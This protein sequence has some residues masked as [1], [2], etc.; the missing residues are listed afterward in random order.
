MIPATD[1]GSPGRA[2]LGLLREVT[3]AEWLAQP[4]FDFALLKS[5]GMK[6][7]DFRFET[8]RLQ[9][10]EYDKRAMYLGAA[11]SAKLGIGAPEFH[12]H[13]TIWDQAGLWHVHVE[14]YPT[15]LE[16]LPS[17]VEEDDA[18]DSWQYTPV[19]ELMRATGYTFHCTE[20]YIWQRQAQVF[21]P[22]YERVRAMRQASAHS[23][24]ELARVK[25]IYTVTFGILAHELKDARPGY[26]FR[27]DWFFG[28]VSYAKLIMWRQMQRV[29]LAEGVAPSKVLVDAVTYPRLVMGLPVGDGIGQF[30]LK[31]LRGE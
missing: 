16:M 3:P 26:L 31:M 19:V 18:A 10:A 9:R 2:C 8:A 22:F 24:E 15:G 5:D 20:A 14:R 21:R 1:A 29:Y 11:S 28:L 17:I 23:P 25:R 6:T 4:D 13:P 27:P 30:K 7:R 12:R